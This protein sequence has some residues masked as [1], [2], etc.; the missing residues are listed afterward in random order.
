MF[1]GKDMDKPKN[2]SFKLLEV[3]WNRNTS[4]HKPKL[5]PELKGINIEDSVKKVK[6]PTKSP[7]VEINENKTEHVHKRVKRSLFRENKNEKVYKHSNSE[8]L[9]QKLC[10]TSDYA[11]MLRKRNYSIY[12]A[13][14][15][16]C[17][18][19]S[20]QIVSNRKSIIRN[21]DT[22][23]HSSKQCLFPIK[24]SKTEIS[25]SH[26][27]NDP[28]V[29]KQSG[30]KDQLNSST[31]VFG[32]SKSPE[33]MSN[34]KRYI[35]FN[36]FDKTD[37]SNNERLNMSYKT[38]VNIPID[39][40][41]EK[42]NEKDKNVNTHISSME[43]KLNSA[44]SEDIIESSEKIVLPAIKKTKKKKNKQITLNHI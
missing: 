33:I 14:Q 21:Q 9:N 40:A 11:N 24:S 6:K 1:I 27:V 25:S 38:C 12:K 31:K 43:L 42:L 35:M 20:P 29:N 17:P 5:L 39:Q 18:T 15:L 2:S 37:V 4:T 34:R 19:K 26:T 28:S 22:S 30:T 41:P 3:I 10:E 32:Y 7:D 8:E 16:N 23:L 36:D 44:N 13:S